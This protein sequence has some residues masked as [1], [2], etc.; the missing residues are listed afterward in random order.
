MV[1][2]EDLKV[3]SVSFPAAKS[4]ESELERAIRDRTAAMAA[5]DHAGSAARGYGHD[6]SR[7]PERIGRHEERSAEDLVQRRSG[8]AD[9]GRRAAGPS[10]RTGH[11]LSTRDQHAGDAVVRY[12]R[13]ALLSRRKWRLGDG[14]HPGRALDGRDKS[15]LRPGSGQSAGRANRSERPPRSLKGRWPAAHKWIA[16]GRICEHHTNGIAGNPRRTPVLA[17]SENQIALRHQHRRQHLP[18]CAHAELL[19][20]SV[21]TVVPEQVVDRGLDLG[22]LEPTPARFRE[23]SS[24]QSEGERAG[25]GS[26]HRTIQGIGDRRSGPANRSGS[27][28]RS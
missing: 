26:R 28:E 10:K 1:V 16:S 18:G 3:S 25:I 14:A 20:T 27:A 21:R 2:L 4:R 8:R 17:Y 19:C 7:G 13:F 22:I 12:F 15:A 6:P 24:R 9:R 11:A 5:H 23:D